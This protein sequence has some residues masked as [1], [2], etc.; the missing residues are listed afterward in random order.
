MYRSRNRST[1]DRPTTPDGNLYYVRLKTPVGTMYKLGFTKMSSV[2]ERLA[3]QK[4]GDEQYIDKVLLFAHRPDA[5]TVEEQLHGY[6]GQKRLFGKYAAQKDRPLAGNGQSELYANDILGLDPE[7]TKIQEKK[8]ILIF[9]ASSNRR[10]F[11]PLV[12]G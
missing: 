9:L 8:E 2:R 5:F 1:L 10:T 3:Y 4:S 7:F 6:F 12:L 11:H